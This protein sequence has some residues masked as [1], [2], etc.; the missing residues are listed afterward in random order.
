MMQDSIECWASGY[1]ILIG[2][3]LVR[4]GARDEA[5]ALWEGAA[6][7]AEARQG[8]VDGCGRMLALLARGFAE[9]GERERAIDVATSI[10]DDVT[11]S[12]IVQEIIKGL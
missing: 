4:V 3:L 1:L 6:R 10:D 2:E 9:I 8:A 5:V 7:R 11:R 12:S